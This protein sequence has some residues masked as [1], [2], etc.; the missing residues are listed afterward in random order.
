MAIVVPLLFF[1]VL[2]LAFGA[3]LEAASRKSQARAEANVTRIALALP[4]VDC[5]A[6]GYET[7]LAFAKAVS[8]GKAEPT[9]CIPGG[10]KSAHEIG[11]ILG[12]TVT[13]ADPVMAVI[14]CKGGDKEASHRCEYDGI[15]DCH[16]A[17][18]AGNG[19]K[20]CSD[21][22]LG[23]GSCVEACPFDAIC[24]NENGIA[25]V[26]P[27]ACTGCGLC[28]DA[29]PRTVIDL[30]P[31][32]HKIYL[33]CVNHDR[34]TRVKKYCEV[35]C[36]A[37]TLCVKASPS[38]A[39]SMGDNLPVLNYAMGENFVVAAHACPAHCFVDLVKHRP[40]V[41]IDAK[42]TGCG[43]CVPACPTDAISGEKGRRH[44]VTKE[45]CIGCGLCLNACPVHAIA[46]WGGLGY[47]EDTKRR[48]MRA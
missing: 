48:L 21:S 1:G 18:L 36:T 5:R 35:G 25:V 45:K 42:C 26:S 20:T 13:P 16:A 46:M 37:C 10:A 17:I 41:N 19:H 22:C 9:G 12:I 6:C 28:V 23:L 29:C 2:G 8:E 40:K 15:V 38:G 14:H 47:A 27:D 24:I 39:I 34:G 44:V 4:N 43:D 32:V 3:G 31:R 11:D 33:A 7:C 30:I